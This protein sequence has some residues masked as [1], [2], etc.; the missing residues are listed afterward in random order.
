VR[1]G[2]LMARD[3]SLADGNSNLH[4][5]VYDHLLHSG[6]RCFLV[7][8]HDEATGLVTPNEVKGIAQTRWPYTIVFDVMRPLERQRI[9][10]TETPVSK[11][12]EIIGRDDINF[13]GERRPSSQDIAS[14]LD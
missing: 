14:G 10:T 4:T 3:C 12:L 9:V 2:D 5:F 8:E 1:V 13:N 7:A 11:A 6:Q